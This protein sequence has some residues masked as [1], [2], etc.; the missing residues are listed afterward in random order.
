MAVASPTKEK[1]EPSQSVEPLLSSPLPSKPASDAGSETSSVGIG[2]PSDRNEQSDSSANSRKDIEVQSAASLRSEEYRQLFRLPPE[3]ALIQDF[4]CALQENILLQGHMYLF[5]NH[6]CFYSNIFGFETKKIIPFHEVTCVRKAKTAAIFPNAIEILAG[7]KKH[8]FASFLSRDEAY[9][10]IVDGWAQ[11]NDR[12]KAQ[13]DCQ[14]SKSESRNQDNALVI[15]ENF[16]S[17][18][19]PTN[20]LNPMDRNEDFQV[21]EECNHLSSGEDDPST[22]TRHSEAQ[23]NVEVDVKPVTNADS[24]SSRKSLTWKLEDVN[25]PKIPECYTLVA[26]SKFPIQVEEFF[27]LFFS[28]DAVNF[29]E[30]FHTRCGDKDFQCTSWYEHEQFGCSR[31]VSFQHPIKLYFGARY[32][33]CQ[34]NQKFRVYKD[35]HLVVET[36]QEINDVPYGDYFRVQG[37]WDVKSSGN[38]GNDYCILHIYI[39]VDF[40]KKTM[41]RGKIEQSTI[42]ECQDAYSIWIKNAH[43]L[44]KQNQLA[45]QEVLTDAAQLERH[46]NIQ[47]P[48]EGLQDVRNHAG[49]QQI[50]S[51]SMDA[52]KQSGNPFQGI[53]SDTTSTV[54]SFRKPLATFCSYL[55]SQSHLP[56]ILVVTSVLILLMM[57]L[58]IVVLLTRTPQ[59]HVIPQADYITGIGNHGDKVEEIAWLE[60]RVNLLRDEIIVVEARIRKMQHEYS[61]LKAH[62]KDLEQLKKL[63]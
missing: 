54:S 45:K 27:N 40:S 18:E 13:I 2:D 15:F 43:E 60:K 21:P 10:L 4:N 38:E 26:E 46:A 63:R 58:S 17:F 20:Y 42:D 24:F 37:L 6:I 61:E 30:S 23:E 41:W 50:A 47:E 48:S 1:S 34:E 25:A 12:F 57:Q 51:D 39:N 56:L 59:V 28:D 52:N 8:F 7:G 22:S 5:V 31:D 53:L 55:K 49:V 35:R 32:G 19:Q 33:H 62:L 44:L 11:Y 3:E 14:E 29:I 36:S 16:K 9:C